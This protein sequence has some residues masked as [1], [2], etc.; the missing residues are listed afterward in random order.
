MSPEQLLG[1]EADARS[2]VYSAGAC[3]YELAT[4]RRPHGGKSGAL[5][6][7]AILHETPEPASRVKAGVPEGLE[8]VIAK[9]M[10]KDPRLRYQTARELL[11]DLERLQQGSETAGHGASRT[12]QDSP[13]TGRRVGRWVGAA[14]TGV[15][16]VGLALLGVPPSPPRIT[17]IRPL[18]ANP[19][20]QTSGMGGFVGW[21]TDGQRLYY[22]ATKP[23]GQ[24]GPFQMSVNGGDSS[25]IALPFGEA[26]RIYGYLPRESALLM[27]GAMAFPSLADP[28]FR[29]EG[30]PVWVVPVPAGAAQRLGIHA[31][32]A[33]A[34]PDGG[35][36]AL[37]Q[38]RRI[39]ITRR[40]GTPL[41]TLEVD[42]DNIY[43]VV[44][45]P[46]NRHVRFVT[47]ATRNDR[48]WL[49]ERDADGRETPRRLAL[50]PNVGQWTPDGRHYLLTAP[51][52]EERRSDLYV[53]AQPRFPWSFRPVSSPLTAG[54]L[55]LWAPG[56]SPDGRRL[57]ALGSSPRR[58]L[59][60]YDARAQRF[61]LFL[62]GLSATYVVPS[63]DGGW[64]AWT[65]LPD[66]SLWKGHPDGTG[67][68]KLLPPG[69]RAVLAHWSPDGR[70]LSFVAALPDERGS[71]PHHLY[72]IS[73]DGGE[74][75]LLVPAPGDRS[76]WDNCWLPDG[77]TIVYSNLRMPHQ[78]LM[79]VD[80][81][82]RA[83][84]PFPGGERF[85][86][87]KCSAQ[88]DILAGEFAPD[89]GPPIHWLFDS[90]R[91][92][93]RRLG[94]SS[95]VHS[96]WTRDGRSIVGLNLVAKRIERYWS[97]DTDR[98]EPVAD[99]EGLP[100]FVFMDVPWV[101][102]DADDRPLVTADRSTHDLYALDWEAR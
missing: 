98:V 62:G 71:T 1:K 94:P 102:L 8:A 78:G 70:S 19:G 51:N 23:N 53:E 83:V 96:S 3:L 88:G 35:R 86:Y 90:S 24:Q 49:W 6:V 28:T 84:S 58:E 25:E 91:R 7:D 63:P 26:V 74:P 76:L 11:V 15:G 56:P 14:L 77:H 4:G 30:V 69:W 43:G 10:D 68:L 5:L 9:A 92:A 79:Q 46:D 21:A 32:F 67:R 87:P 40:D 50:P 34:S 57:F 100:L 99:V 72:R 73:A 59:L 31:F 82:T 95:H 75:E 80:V 81:R 60:R 47:G 54:P 33:A 97:R 20:L 55:D 65:G 27:S 41:R 29:A 48:S 44:W 13:P 89:S 36:L 85:F 64:L 39:L 38:R 93:W 61:E 42:A 2:D 37:T 66:G 18:G 45:N 16:L 12:E 52:I 22:V 101:G 17:N